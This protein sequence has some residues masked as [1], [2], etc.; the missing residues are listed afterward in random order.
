MLAGS[1]V[2]CCI[3][4]V[5]V[6]VLTGVGIG[7]AVAIPVRE[8]TLTTPPDLTLN[9]EEVACRVGSEREGTPLMSWAGCEPLLYTQKGVKTTIMSTSGH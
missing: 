6:V 8:G 2:R 4:L 1:P 5:V 7:G 3:L 9:R